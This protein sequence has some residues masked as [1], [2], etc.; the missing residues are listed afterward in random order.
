MKKY[1]TTPE[2]PPR[3][4]KTAL[5]KTKPLGNDKTFWRIPKE[6]CQ[7]GIFLSLILGTVANT[8]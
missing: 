2:K 6:F 3:E 7:V 1:K 5:A 4:G 8:T